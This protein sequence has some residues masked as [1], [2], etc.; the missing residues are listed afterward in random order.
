MRISKKFDGIFT[1]EGKL[2]TLNYVPGKTVYGEKT[3]KVDKD[4]YRFWDAYRSKLAGAILKGLESVPI[5]NRSS[6][7]YLG[8]ST[9]TT[10]SHVSD[11]VRGN[12]IVYCVEFAQRVLGDLIR[13][14]ETR[15]NMIPI[16][17]DARKPE[18]YAD[19]IEEKV[20]VI[21]QDVA[22]KDQVRILA[23]NTEAYLKKGGEVLLCVKSQSIDVTKDPKKIYEQV[24]KELEEEGF[25]VLQ[26]LELK[27]YD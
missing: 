2:A 19:H 24:L 6:V 11:I 10:P 22:Q 26:T 13:V 7:L 17:A 27:P 23:M 4:E 14:A 9:G 3:V 18:D 12:G 8:A 25:T 16:F 15:D 1:I 20:D 5:K 21:Y